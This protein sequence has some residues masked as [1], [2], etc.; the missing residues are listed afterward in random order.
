[1]TKN[2]SLTVLLVVVAMTVVITG[3]LMASNMGFKL[4]RA[5]LAQT[6]PNSASGTQFMGLPYNR[7][8]GIDTA[9]D[10][11][12]DMGTAQNIQKWN[13]ATDSYQAYASGLGDFP[14]VSGQGVVAKM[15]SNT[16]YIIVGSHDP[17]LQVQL[18]AQGGASASGT[19]LFAPPYHAT[20]ATA[21]A[22][23]EELGSDYVQNI[24]RYLTSSDS[25]QAYASGLSDFPL[26]PG[27]AYFVK[28]GQAKLYTPSHY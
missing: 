19:N 20:A 13:T 16:N 10:L 18:E 15:G 7:Q 17:S 28:M 1:M 26:V 11:F 22:L 8:V 23:F 3:G 6:D 21:R 12:V 4:N 9:R 25:Y 2:R 5:L 14:L 27:E 24:Q